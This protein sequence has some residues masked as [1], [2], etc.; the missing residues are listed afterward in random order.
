MKRVTRIEINDIDHIV[1]YNGDLLYAVLAQLNGMTARYVDKTHIVVA[2]P[3]KKSISVKI[4][5]DRRSPKR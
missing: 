1:R 5:S 2:F 3:D 4:K